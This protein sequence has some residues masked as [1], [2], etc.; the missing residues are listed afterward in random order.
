VTGRFGGP[1]AAL[2]A[3]AAGRVPAPSH[4]RRFA[5]PVPRVAEARWLAERGAT[6]MIDVSDG[7]ASELRH[8]A[9]ASNVSIDVEL[10]RLPLEDG[11]RADAAVVSGEEYELLLAARPGID[12]AAFASTFALPLTV[13][14]RVSSAG[15]SGVRVT[16]SGA[17]VDLGPGYDHF[18]H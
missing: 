7:V 10:E 14:G 6:A 18:S 13:I 8:L 3:L 5:H 2:A 11:V 4:R 9:A 12:V 15:A 17:R 1:G 16:S